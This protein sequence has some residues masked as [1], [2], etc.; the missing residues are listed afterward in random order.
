MAAKKKR[1]GGV[2]FEQ[3][4]DKSRSQ[5][6]RESTALQKRGEELA[7]LSPVIQAKLPL[8]PEL[9][10]ALCLWRGLKTWEARRRHMQYIG[11]LLR[12]MDEA[13]ALLDALEAISANSQRAAR[14]FRHIEELR[15]S[16]LQADA[17]ERSAILD[18]VLSQNS[19]LDRARLAHLVEAAVREREKQRPPKHAR[20]L[21][22][23]LRDNQG[24]PG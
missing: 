5:K 2:F 20:E 12:E 16:L 15:D 6:K 4:E 3:E 18:A 22:R 19:S 11:R 13:E 7:A 21:F 1:D 9:E 24:K 23:Y 14:D 8:T 10:E 17:E